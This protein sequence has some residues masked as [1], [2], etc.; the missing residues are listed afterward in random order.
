MSEPKQYAEV[1]TDHDL[2]VRLDERYASMHSDLKEI[3]GGTTTRLEA[4][5]R[6]VSSL[7]L[8][9]SALLGAFAV[10]DLILIPLGFAYFT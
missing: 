2:L 9:R 1:L 3:K 6:K 4:L 10:F 7:E 5:E 8:W